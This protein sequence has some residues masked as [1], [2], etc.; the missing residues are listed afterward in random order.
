MTLYGHLQGKFLTE[1]VTAVVLL[2]IVP[3]GHLQGR[4]LTEN[5][6]GGPTVY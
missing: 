2:F 5:V 1:N 4:F 6:T 3:N